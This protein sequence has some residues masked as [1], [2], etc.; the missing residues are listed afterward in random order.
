MSNVSLVS[1]ESFVLEVRYIVL[2]ALLWII[3]L[4][5]SPSFAQAPS[6]PCEASPGVAQALAALPQADDS[7]LTW[8]ERVGPVQALLK[9]YPDDLFVQLRYQEMLIR[10][11][12]MADEYDSALALY[13]SMP[14][15]TLAQYLEARLLWRSQVRR[16]RATLNRLLETAPSFPWPH[17]ALVETT[18]GP[19]PADITLAETHLRAF[20]KACPNALEPYTHFKNVNDSEMTQSAA[21]HLREL[22]AGR[23][24]AAIWGYYPSLW[25]LEF[26]A[27]PTQE[28][29]QVRQ[30]VRDDVKRLQSLEQVGSNAWYWAYRQASEL[31]EDP[32]I[33]SW[34]DNVVLTRFP[35]SPLAVVLAEEQW[36]HDH[37][38]PTSGDPDDHKKWEEQHFDAIE[39]RVK[40]W[41]DSPYLSMQEWFAVQELPDLPT[42]KVLTISDRYMPIVA[43]QPDFSVSYPPFA[44]VAA[45]EY[46]KRK[47][48]LDCV[49]GIIQ[50]GLHQAELQAKYQIDP[51]LLPADARR[52]GNDN[53]TF[54]IV[55]HAPGF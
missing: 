2:A 27:A 28:H 32:S 35:N 12:W 36:M 16:S 29:D 30:R 22:L 46:V 37:P 20:L 53:L 50:A 1:G 5:G 52:P 55:S 34:L 23:T 43:A 14:D 19:G 15:R 31:A 42:E 41:P 21:V 33:R 49:P 17:L 9:Q 47:V 8:A 18:E 10:H 3:G 25:E 26:R 51:E 6:Y 7:N 4:T 44:I 39:G 40:R 54:A 24:D 11:E 13:R 38:L 48:R 45:E